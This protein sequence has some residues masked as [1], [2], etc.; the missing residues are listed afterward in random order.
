MNNTSLTISNENNYIAPARCFR[1][2]TVW[3]HIEGVWMYRFIY[4]IKAES[5][6]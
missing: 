4:R 2:R 1:V 3:A 6:Y 5:T